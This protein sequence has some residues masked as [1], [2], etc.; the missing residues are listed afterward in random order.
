MTK[1][2]CAVVGCGARSFGHADAYRLVSRGEL[3]ACCDLLPEKRGKYSTQYGLRAYAEVSEMLEKE[4]PD[5]V[6]LVTW[7]QSRVELMTLVDDYK[8]PTCIVEKPIACGVT[9]W[10]QLVEL[11]SKAHTKFTVCHQVRWHPALVASRQALQSGRLGKLLFLDFTARFNISGQG[12]HILDYGMSLND[13][14]PVI[15]VFGCASG[16]EEMQSLHPGPDAT[17]AQVLFSNGVY[18]LWSTGSTSP[19][20]IADNTP[21][22]H[23]RVAAYAERGRTLYEEFGQWEIISPEGREG[24]QVD[25]MGAWAKGNTL[26]QAGLLNAMFDWLEDSS[27]PASTSL[28]RGLHQW[29]VVLG[30]YASQVWRRPVDIPFDAPD[31]LLPRLINTL[32]DL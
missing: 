15:R 2:R 32:G 9:D 29:Q 27:K 31:D 14:F 30:L 10:K 11:E 16:Q 3:V 4:K 13:D 22:K 8:V 1:Y 6:H 28:K 5:L 7:P 26:A 12:T 20:A 17:V 25:D 24:G 21:W 23:V 19:Q 18:G